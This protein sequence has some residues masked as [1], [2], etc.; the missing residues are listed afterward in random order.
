MY[1]SVI[2][3]P[4]T[5]VSEPMRI[6]SPVGGATVVSVGCVVVSGGAVDS[7]A[8]VELAVVVTGSVGADVGA[9]DAAGADVALPPASSSSPHAACSPVPAGEQP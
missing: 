3:S 6:G 8:S 4:V 5:V 7:V 1:G 2:S 9:D